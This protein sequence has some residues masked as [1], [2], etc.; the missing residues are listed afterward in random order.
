MS[1]ALLA[2]AAAAML[3]LNTAVVRRSMLR[4]SAYNGIVISIVL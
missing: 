2:L 1:G 3:G 4:A